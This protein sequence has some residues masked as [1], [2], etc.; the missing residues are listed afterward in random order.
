MMKLFILIPI[1]LLMSCIKEVNEEVNSGKKSVVQLVDKSATHETRNLFINLDRISKDKVLYGQQ[2][3]LYDFGSQQD[4]GK[5][6]A[7]SPSVFGWDLG[8]LGTDQ[9]FD[10]LK[11]KNLEKAMIKVY[12][13]GG[14]NALSWNIEKPGGNE[15]I[16]ETDNYVRSVLPGGYQ[17]ENYK[18]QLINFARFNSRLL[19]TTGCQVPILFRALYEQNGNW[20]WWGKKYCSSEEYKNLFKF[21]VLYLK[22]S[23]NVHNLIYV[24]S[25]DGRFDDYLERYPGDE[26]VD[27]IGLDF[28]FSKYALSKD[29]E[30]YNKVVAEIS[31]LS[32]SKS[33]LSAVS[34]VGWDF[35]GLERTQTKSLIEHIIGR[36]NGIAITYFILFNNE[37][38]NYSGEINSID[39][40]SDFNGF[41]KSTNTYF[42]KNLPNVYANYN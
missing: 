15:I 39:P 31:D 6:A 14:I 27:I 37:L 38:E 18:R 11:N 3:F 5:K 29:M 30:L 19:D 7:Y 34:E 8:S 36:K 40:N 35:S 4:F 41:Y 32:K 10:S 26:Y 23:L 33:K 28:Y 20:F 22:D 9:E 17:H 13:L 42:L 12:H 1:L 21:T 2:V 25:P 24:F 16:P